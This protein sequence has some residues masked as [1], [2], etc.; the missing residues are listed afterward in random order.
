MKKRRQIC[1]L[2]SAFTNLKF[3]SDWLVLNYII[4]GGLDYKKITNRTLLSRK[5]LDRNY[6]K[7]QHKNTSDF[8]CGSGLNFTSGST[9]AVQLGPS[10]MIWGLF[11]SIDVFSCRAS[12]TLFALLTYK[13]HDKK[14]SYIKIKK[15]KEE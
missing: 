2:W 8:K 3:W 11:E 12:R 1:K 13:W 15:Y 6:K 4:G 9:F 5:H 7:A 14:I 10:E